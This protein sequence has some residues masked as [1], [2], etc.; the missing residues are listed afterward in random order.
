MMGGKK[1]INV[2]R[3]RT[4]VHIVVNCKN[5]YIRRNKALG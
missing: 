5:S 1:M 3:G 2:E 4:E